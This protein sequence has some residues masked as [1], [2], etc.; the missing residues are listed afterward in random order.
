MG[1][2]CS[3]EQTQNEELENMKKIKRCWEKMELWKGLDAGKISLVSFLVHS[4]VY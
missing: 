2:L 3:L 1:E 4:Y